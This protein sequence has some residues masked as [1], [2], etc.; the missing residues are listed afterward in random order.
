VVNW[1]NRISGIPDTQGRV[2][3]HPNR[4]EAEWMQ[5][6]RYVPVDVTPWETASGGKAIACSQ[7]SCSATFPF[8]RAEGTYDLVVQ[9]FDQ[10]NGASHFE[11]FV[12]DRSIGR[13]A[14]DDHFPSDKMNGDT[15][16]R[17][18]FE[19]VR[20][21]SAD[22]V[23]IVGFPDGGEPAGLDYIEVWATPART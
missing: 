2:G 6:S 1:F 8:T 7:T 3:H 16:T 18:V 11:L 19:R 17:K 14:A 9:Y 12:N 10:N 20:L 5:L 4:I 15:S 21:Q 22:T 23:K 13:W